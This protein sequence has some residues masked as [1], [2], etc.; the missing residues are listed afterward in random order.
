M[1]GGEVG[2]DRAVVIAGRHGWYRSLAWDAEIEAGFEER[3]RR[4]RPAS[5]SQYIRIQATYLLES[6]DLGVREAG[7]GLLRRVI[8]EYPDDVQAKT[9]MEQFGSSLAGEA[10]LGE[11]EEALRETLRMCAASPA[12]RSGTTGTTELRLAEVILAAGDA[13]RIPEAAELLD[14]A[15]PQVMRFR[16]FRN[17]VFR[18][19]LASARVA[20]LRH[21][22]AARQLAR[23]ALAVAAETTPSF[24]RH[25]G[26][27]RPSASE[28]EVAELEKIANGR[29]QAPA[30]IPAI[31]HEE[32]GTPDQPDLNAQ[33]DQRLA[34]H[35]RAIRRLCVRR[36]G[37]HPSLSVTLAIGTTFRPTVD[38]APA[39]H[40]TCHLVRRRSIV[41]AGRYQSSSPGAQIAQHARP[42]D[43]AA[44]L[45]G[46]F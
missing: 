12:G 26:A 41:S 44:D 24:P 27:G 11:A 9:A 15:Q 16:S 25:P 1:S 29:S 4:A 39:G 23:R 6:S 19:L 18:Y 3:L 40:A 14:A 31:S 32:H 38:P 34:P 22:P 8:A 2:Q 20:W 36:L 13:A 28:D 7:R 42:L 5:R 21:D 45:A 30:C 37:S 10:R 35:S 46:R 33:I 43:R 17:V